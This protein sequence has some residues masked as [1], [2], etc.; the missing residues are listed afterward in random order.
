[1][2]NKDSTD[3]MKNKIAELKLKIEYSI[4]EKSM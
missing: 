3:M 1:M 2:N 4:R